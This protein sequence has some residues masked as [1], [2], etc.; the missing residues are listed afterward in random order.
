M[1]NSLAWVSASGGGSSPFTVVQ[2]VDGAAMAA[3]GTRTITVSAGNGLLIGVRWDTPATNISSVTITSES[4]ATVAGTKPT[5]GGAPDGTCQW[6]YLLNITTGGAKTVTVNMSGATGIEVVVMEIGG[7]AMTFDT[8]TPAANTGTSTNPSTTI[9]T[10]GVDNLI[11]ALLLD[12]GG[13]STAGSGYTQ[14]TIGEVA[15][16]DSLMYKVAVG[17]AGSKTVDWANA[18][19]AP[20]IM[21]VITMKH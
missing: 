13:P 6:A 11:A 14:V 2:T 5:N 21:S 9:T 16:S 3:P 19:S 8:A 1:A 17:A 20:W 18:V 15:Y 7:D 4:N 10:A 12:T